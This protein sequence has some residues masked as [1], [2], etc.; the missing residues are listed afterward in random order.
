MEANK[1]LRWLWP[2]WIFACAVSVL[3]LILRLHALDRKS[4]WFDEGASIAIARL[5]RY[6]FLRL[7]WRREANM[8]LYYLL[9]RAW[10]HLCAS[11]FFIRSLSVI[12][13]VVAI[14]AC[15]YLA[16]RLFDRKVAIISSLLLAVNAYQIRY[17]QEARS[18]SLYICLALVSCLEL[19]RYLQTGRKRDR[20]AYII[21]SS[22]AVYAHFYFAFVIVAHWIAMRLRLRSEQ[23]ENVQQSFYWIAGATFPAF[24]FAATTGVGP[25][26]WIQPPTLTDLYK[27]FQYFSGNG[28]WLLLA[29][30]LIAAAIGVSEG[31]SGLW[32]RSATFDVWR[33]QFLLS[34]LLVPIFLVFLISYARPLFL[35]RYFTACQP[36]FLILVAAGITR[37]PRSWVQAAAVLLMS[38][39]ALHATLNYYERD[40]D[41]ARDDYR[42]ASYYVLD[43]SQAGDA[44]VFDIAMGRMPYEYYRSLRLQND[45]APTVIYPG[46]PHHIEYHDFLGKPNPGL[47][48]SWAKN[49]RL[50]LVSKVNAV[51]SAPDP[52]EDLIANLLSHE[53]STVEEHAYP[54]VI[55][56]LYSH[57]SSSRH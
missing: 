24:L 29:S 45:A 32:R 49:D 18:Y 10:Q 21:A 36:A 8:A 17:A 52:G 34:I 5:D 38:V 51:Q 47:I 35:P 26:R 6:N 16:H 1:S 30:S 3:A 39:L 9:L 28:G 27:L 2:D 15:Y 40:F 55:V 4:F 14:P 11:E 44:L 13:S 12:F 48:T 42:S 19:V 50:W 7:I 25:L 43:H 23:S 20:Q 31:G 41:L 46:K 22:L 33:Y 54:G 53:Y 56:R 37:I 57:P